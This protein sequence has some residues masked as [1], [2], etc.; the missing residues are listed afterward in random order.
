MPIEHRG[1]GQRRQK[2][3]GYGESRRQNRADV[4]IG[5]D[6]RGLQRRYKDRREVLRRKS[7]H[8]EEDSILPM[9]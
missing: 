7:D 4:F 6:R 5:F 2:T 9:F 1:E 3:H 8:L